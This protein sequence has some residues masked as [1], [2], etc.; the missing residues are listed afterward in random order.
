[1]PRDTKNSTSRISA[2]AYSLGLAVIFSATILNFCL[3]K[4]PPK[5]LY[6]LPSFIVE[7]YEEGGNLG[8]TLT[9]AGF[10]LFLLLLGYLSTFMTGKTTRSGGHTAV[11]SACAPQ[12][13]DPRIA[14][15]TPSTAS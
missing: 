11:E 7:P 15:A 13:S 5:H 9:L 10:G 1:M 2:V 8:V 14:V 3:H 4:L 6:S 12:Y